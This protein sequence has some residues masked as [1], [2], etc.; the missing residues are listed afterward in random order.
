MG[1]GSKKEKDRKGVRNGD[2]KGKIRV[3]PV[4]LRTKSCS[5]KP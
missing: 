4:Q 1:K 5:W 3:Q 2:R